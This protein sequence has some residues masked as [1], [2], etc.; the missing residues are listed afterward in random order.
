MKNITGRSVTH[1][2]QNTQRIRRRASAAPNLI[3]IRFD[4]STAK[5]RLWFKRRAIAAPNSRAAISQRWWNKN[6]GC[7]S[8]KT[9]A[10]APAYQIIA[11]LEKKTERKPAENASPF[12]SKAQCC[13]CNLVS[14]LHSCFRQDFRKLHCCSILSTTTTTQLRMVW[15][16]L[17]YS[18]KK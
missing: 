15:T 11:R 5:P 14:L 9:A 2:E 18:A 17:E 6:N 3:A 8:F 12:A 10:K 4:C 1:P 16:S 7:I 13:Y